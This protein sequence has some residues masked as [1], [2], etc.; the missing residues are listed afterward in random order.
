MA[1]L[2]TQKKSLEK[3]A[4][5]WAEKY[6]LTRLPV[7]FSKCFSWVFHYWTFS[8]LYR[9]YIFP[10]QVLLVFT[11]IMPAKIIC[12]VDWK[13]FFFLEKEGVRI[14]KCWTRLPNLAPCPSSLP[15]EWPE[16][17]LLPGLVTFV[18][19]FFP[20]CVGVLRTYEFWK[21]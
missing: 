17:M 8:F 12:K 11:S 9:V 2:L 21:M 13:I 4:R 1:V 7:Q 19:G 14:Q 6:H 3:R 15:L 5:A 10:P 18:N 16:E 20:W